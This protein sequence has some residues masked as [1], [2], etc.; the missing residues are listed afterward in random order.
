MS[1]LIVFEE[2]ES[3]FERRLLTFA[4]V[5]V[6]H[7]NIREFLGDAFH[8]F[9]ENVNNLLVEHTLVKVN[10]VLKLVFAKYG[11]NEE[12]GA[13]T[14]INRDV[15][16]STNM[17]VIDFET[18]LK[19]HY[20]EFIVTYLLSRFDSFVMEGSGVS[21]SKINE[22]SVQVVEFHPIRGS[23]HIELPHHLKIKHAVINV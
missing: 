4:V 9:E 7:I 20:N 15:F 5:N 2:R 3:A 1:N 21:L 12:N 8:Y 6:E 19:E 13:E 17:Y 16:I 22:L 10:T 11:V 14:V 18:N 23:T